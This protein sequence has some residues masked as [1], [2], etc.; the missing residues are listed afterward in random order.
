MAD[1]STVLRWSAYEHDH[2]ERGSDWYWALGIV[3]VCIAIISILLHDTLFALVVLMAAFTLALLSRHPPELAHF[4]LSEK[5]V[6]INE[7][8][9]RYNEIIS[10]WV[11]DEHDGKPLL[12]IDTVKFL[13]PNIVIPIE[14]IDPAVVRA[15]LKERIE[16]VRMKESFA[17]KIF[18]FLGL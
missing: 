10:F 1:T 2:I 3:A 4:E 6:R 14:H 18:E 5:G 13:S 7:E 9:H 8:L 16:E 11:E 15:F 17:H 12:L